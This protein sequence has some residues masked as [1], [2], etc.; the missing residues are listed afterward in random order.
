MAKDKTSTKQVGV[1]M[2]RSKCY[3]I[4]DVT[5]LGGVTSRYLS[6]RIYIKYGPGASDLWGYLMHVA[7][8]L[9][10]DIIVFKQFKLDMS[11]V[12]VEYIPIR[13]RCRQIGRYMIWMTSLETVAR[14]DRRVEC[15][16]QGQLYSFLGIG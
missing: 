6:S 5:W 16:L 1:S 8:S 2:R 15:P 9:R 3:S 7:M 14:W 10:H 11:V 12:R 4:P 13:T